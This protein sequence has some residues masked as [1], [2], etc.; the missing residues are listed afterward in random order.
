MV[1]IVEW[2]RIRK[3][4][5][6]IFIGIGR[7]IVTRNIHTKNFAPDVGGIL[8]GTPRWGNPA[9]VIIAEGRI[10]GRDV[11]IVA[12]FMGGVGIEADPIHRVIVLP[13]IDRKSTRLNSSHL[14]ISYA[15]FC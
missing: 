13:I 14:V 9:V 3:W 1:R 12:R 7:I 4:N 15:V 8:G 11:E 5:G 2:N 6:E 10:A